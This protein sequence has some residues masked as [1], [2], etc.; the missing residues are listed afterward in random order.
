MGGW[1]SRDDSASASSGAAE[2]FESAGFEVGGFGDTSAIC[3]ISQAF[4]GRRWAFADSVS[5]TA[6]FWLNLQVSASSLDTVKPVE[7]HQRLPDADKTPRPLVVD[8]PIAFR[9]HLCG[10]CGCD[11]VS[12]AQ[13]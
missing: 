11:T 7:T 1:L 10:F 12:D 4:V 6:R 5:K 2:V 3:R 8:R 13:A 9:W